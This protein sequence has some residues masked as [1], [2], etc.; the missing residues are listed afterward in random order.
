MILHQQEIESGLRDLQ[1]GEAPV[2]VHASLSSF[3]FVEGGA[4]AVAIQV[5]ALCGKGGA[6]GIRVGPRSIGGEETIVV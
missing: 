2:I 5:D 6:A 4:T 3:G 1:L